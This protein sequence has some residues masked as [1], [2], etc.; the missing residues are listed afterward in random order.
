MPYDYELP[1]RPLH[2]KWGLV[3]A[4]SSLF[5][6]LVWMQMA[7]LPSLN[8]LLAGCSGFDVAPPTRVLAGLRVLNEPARASHWSIL[9]PVC[10]IW[11][12]EG[13]RKGNC[14]SLVSL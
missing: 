14:R 7:G 13:Y 8:Q 5:A 11:T 10:V 12:V 2:G 6:A 4:T 3:F 9:L 1:H